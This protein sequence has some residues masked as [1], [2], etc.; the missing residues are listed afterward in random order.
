VANWD[1]TLPTVTYTTT[2]GATATLA[3]TITPVD[4]ATVTAPDLARGAEDTSIAGNV[5]ANDS[6]VDSALAVVSFRLAGSDAVH[7]AGSTATLAG[8][9]TVLVRTDGSYLFT[10]AADWN[11]AVPALS[12]TT[13]TGVTEVLQ[14]A[15]APVNDAPVRTGTAADLSVAEGATAPL[16]FAGV[17][18]GT[19]G[20]ADE[21]TQML[22]VRVAALPTALGTVTLADGS[23]VRIGDSHT[24]AELQGMQFHAAPGVS[25]E[26]LFAFTVG[27]DAGGTG[28]LAQSLVVRVTNVAPLLEGT[29]A[30]PTVRE[31]ASDNGGM[32]VGDLIAGHASDPGARLG[33]AVTEAAARSGQWE[34]SRDG[35]ATWSAFQG[36]SA[37][38]A[39]LLRADEQT[40]IRFVG[41][42]D[43]NGSAGGLAFRAWDLSGGT[44]DALRGDTTANGGSAAFSAASALT[45]IR[46]EA[47]NDAPQGLADAPAQ[48]AIEDSG[49]A[50]VLT[51]L[52]WNY[53]PGGGRDEA[54]QSITITITQV[55]A[56]AVGTLVLADG[57]TPVREGDSYSA[58]QLRGV[59]FIPAPGSSGR[60]GE[61]AW[62]ARDDGGTAGGGH[63]S[64]T[65]QVRLVVVSQP[66][67]VP[68]AP[69]AAAPA[70]LPEPPVQVE[71]AAPAAAPAA[72]NAPVR[73]RDAAGPL[74]A[75]G[76]MTPS[77]VLMPPATEFAFAIQRP[78]ETQDTARILGS[79]PRMAGEFQLV[80]FSGQGGLE[81]ELTGL[82]F[83]VSSSSRLTMEQFQQSLRSGIFVEELNRLRDE[84]RQEFD[85]DKSLS[86][87]VAGLSLG[88]SV[89]YVLWLVRGGVLLG[90]YLSALPA[91]RMLD[92]LPVLSRA[93]DEEEEEEDETFDA[94]PGE[95]ADPL[96]GFS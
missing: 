81:F 6:D 72:P 69:I 25:G 20:G 77:S 92:P 34:Y 4:D 51:Q 22:T 19:G 56:P 36:V 96:R 55:P 61:L 70:P 24:V 38:S 14:L 93:G 28:T 85:L 83:Q 53:T 80:N 50:G 23:P 26:A 5:L 1:G 33:I 7:A 30:L 74:D 27:D 2:T 54:G 67:A 16:G 84:L 94:H 47:V 63:D 78:V 95:R 64:T 68:A 73:G 48:L 9:G 46:I 91:W 82:N 76:E 18:Y 71:P 17:A 15:I 60:H 44:A 39:E 65:G 37:E 10:P 90:S 66:P 11:G 42:R 41:N 8:I 3:I 52:P 43:W 29:N 88:V 49:A 45:S 13:S 89:A 87:S 86:I 35:G 79:G 75:V 40:R 62:V 59:Q 32:L 31:D 21:A 57:R 58:E 12:Y